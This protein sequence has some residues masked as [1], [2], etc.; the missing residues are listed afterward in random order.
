MEHD[1]RGVHGFGS[2]WNGDHI[3]LGIYHLWVDATGALRIKNSAPASDLDG[4]VVG[5]QT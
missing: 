4:T 5:T 3:V 2:A 1:H